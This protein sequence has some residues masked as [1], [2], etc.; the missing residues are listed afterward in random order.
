MINGKEWATTQRSVGLI[1]VGLP[2]HI[3][4]MHGS[5][6]TFVNLGNVLKIKDAMTLLTS[7][8][9]GK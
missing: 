9:S 2:K 4:A 6:I 8:T 3:N 5:M 1:A 7:S